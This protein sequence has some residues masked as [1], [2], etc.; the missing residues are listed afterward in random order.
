MAL[1]HVPDM[2]MKDFSFVKITLVSKLYAEQ[3]AK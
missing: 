3:F 2:S 1:K